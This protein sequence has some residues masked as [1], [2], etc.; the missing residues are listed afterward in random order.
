M[1]T[2]ICPNCGKPMK[3][4]NLPKL[5]T[6]TYEKCIRKCDICEIGASNSI[7][8][9]TIIY[10]HLE[11]CIPKQLLENEDIG[12]FLNKSLNRVNITSKINNFK[13]SSSEDAL[14]WIFFIYF[15]KYSRLELLQKLL[16]IANPIKE[17]L[18]WG[19]PLIDETNCDYKNRLIKICLKFGEKINSLSEPDCI[20]ITDEYIYFIEVKL[21]SNNAY[22][23]DLSKFDK[24]NYAKAYINYEEAKNSKL[25]ELA[26]NWSIGSKFSEDKNFYLYNLSLNKFFQKTNETCLLKF[27]NSLTKPENFFQFSWENI[28]NNEEMKKV[29]DWFLEELLFRTGLKKEY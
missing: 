2:V 5:K 26:R 19:N 6:K 28:I 17:I 24:Y 16:K 21:K 13:L 11:S 12:L 1:Q 23:P 9:P 7:E 29:D 10:K 8:S 25:Y 4:F 14:T 3:E 18:L 22:E 15:V 20:I 27:K